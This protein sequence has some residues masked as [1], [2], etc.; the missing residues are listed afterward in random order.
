MI[1]LE[2]PLNTLYSDEVPHDLHFQ[3]KPPAIRQQERPQF[4]LATTTNGLKDGRTPEVHPSLKPTLGPAFFILPYLTQIVLIR[5]LNYSGAH[6][7]E[8]CNPNL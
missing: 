5:G 6:V 7:F 8:D 2:F 3:D 4:T 1:C